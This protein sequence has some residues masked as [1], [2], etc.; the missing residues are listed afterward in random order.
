MWTPSGKVSGLPASGSPGMAA[1]LGAEDDPVEA[2]L[3]RRAGP[4]ARRRGRRSARPPA[5]APRPGSARAAAWCSAKT[6]SRLD[7]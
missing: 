1:E 5:R 2:R 6:P 7:E 4:C 3:A